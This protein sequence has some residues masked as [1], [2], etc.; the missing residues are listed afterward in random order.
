[1]VWAKPNNYGPEMT[2]V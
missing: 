1:L 2:I